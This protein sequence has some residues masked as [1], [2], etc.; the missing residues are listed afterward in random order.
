M[1]SQREELADGDAV[2][3]DDEGLAV[4]ELPHDL[5]AVV[6]QLPLRDLPAHAPTVALRATVRLVKVRI[7]FGLGTAA[8]MAADPATFGPLVDD[9]E[10][11]RFDSLW[12][13]ERLSGPAPDPLAALAFAAGRTTKL[14]LGTS[15]LVVPGRNPAVLASELATIDRLSGGR[16][17]PAI[18]LG[19]V[20]P[21]EQ[22]GFGVER[23][24]RSSWFDEV[25]PLLRRF[26]A[27]EPVDHEGPRFR[28]EGVRILP[29]PVQDPLE[30]WLGGIAPS[31]LRRVGRLGDGWLP[32]FCTPEDVAG[33]RPV[34]AA[35]AA[36]AGREIE[37]EHWG[38]LVLY[39]GGEVPDR[40]AAAVA[41]RRP[42]VDV[43]DLVPADHAALRTTLE[44]FVEV[45]FSKFVVVPVGEPAAWT[46]EL[47][48]LAAAVLPL[49]V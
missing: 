45:G 23:S 2:A 15:V 25:V 17:L 30:L 8:G 37:D 7:G 3:G 32:S 49:Q 14:K 6:P 39:A 10:R 29:T 13:S 26:W 20:D 38:A 22:Q 19:A 4:V 16:L 28:Y 5:A 47:E 35:A 34:V 27:G 9:L 33:A 11:L 42:G 12:L 36:E 21:V 1:A 24:E 40:L 43:A 41:R 31:E 46:D 44:R 48:E 18:G